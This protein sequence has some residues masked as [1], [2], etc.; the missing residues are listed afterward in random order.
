MSGCVAGT[1]LSWGSGRFMLPLR[2]SCGDP[3]APAPLGPSAPSRNDAAG[4][5]APDDA[6]GE[7]PCIVARKG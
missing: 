1:P 7:P 6:N 5:D 3:G 4:L 2:R